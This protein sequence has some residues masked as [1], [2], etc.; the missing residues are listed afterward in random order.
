MEL[1]SV[2]SGQIQDSPGGGG[3]S[4]GRGSAAGPEGRRAAERAHLYNAQRRKAEDAP[5]GSLSRV[6]A[7]SR[8]WCGVRGST[9]LMGD[10]SGAS[11]EPP[12]D[13]ST[14]VRIAAVVADGDAGASGCEMLLWPRRSS[15]SCSSAPAQH[16]KGISQVA[17]DSTVSAISLLPRK[18][19]NLKSRGGPPP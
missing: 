5:A 15:P 18:P 1:V 17:F 7:E 14:V 19:H 9:R 3:V 11:Q 2:L 10:G 13:L 4:D 6:G 8:R 16:S 12:L